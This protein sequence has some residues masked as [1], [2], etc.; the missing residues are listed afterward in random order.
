MFVFYKY[1]RIINRIHPPDAGPFC[2]ADYSGGQL[3]LIANTCEISGAKTSMDFI[4]FERVSVQEAKAVLDGHQVTP[5][6][7][8]NWTM[9]RD[10]SQAKNTDITEKTWNWV[11]M[12]PKEVQ[13]GSLLQRFPR[14][15]N[16]LSELWPRPAQCEKY[17]DALILDLRGSRKG[18]PP[19]IA[20]ELASL[21][22][23]LNPPVV[24]NRTDV[25]GERVS[26]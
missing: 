23:H 11:E 6:P 15:A 14:I 25:W 19:D 18:F 10:A 24:V 12:L 5:I 22:T 26:G 13:P 8:R 1:L 7:E 4:P 9:A 21:K 3:N 20:S 17:L 16:K 2:K